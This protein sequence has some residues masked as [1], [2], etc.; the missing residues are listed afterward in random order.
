M[1]SCCPNTA[2]GA[3]A[4]ALS[5]KPKPGPG[6]WGSPVLPSRA[7][8]TRYRFM[9]PWAMCRTSTG[10]LRA[11]PSPATAWTKTCN[12]RQDVRLHVNEKNHIFSYAN[13]LRLTS[14][15][16]PGISNRTYNVDNRGAF[17]AFY[18]HHRVKGD[19]DQTRHICWL[20]SI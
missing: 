18:D 10:A 12:C 15:C 7:A 19:V 16:K 5:V 20:M 4:H 2:A 1:S 14:N 17:T 3:S 8:T 13:F 9:S 6:N 11:R